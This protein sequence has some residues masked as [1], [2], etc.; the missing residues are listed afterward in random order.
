LLKLAAV[1]AWLDFDESDTLVGIDVQ[2][3]SE[4]VDIQ[5]LVLSRLPL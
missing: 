4:K 2:H 3:A 5:S 1:Y